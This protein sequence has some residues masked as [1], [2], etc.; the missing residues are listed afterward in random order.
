MVLTSILLYPVATALVSG[1]GRPAASGKAR[2]TNTSLRKL[3]GVF[4]VLQTPFDGSGAIDEL[5]LRR[6]S[7]GFSLAA[8]MA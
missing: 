6:R 7:T 5:T 8:C 4:P 3:R 1:V 2:M